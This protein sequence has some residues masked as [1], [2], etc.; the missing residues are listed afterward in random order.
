MKM[1]EFE[2]PVGFK[3]MKNVRYDNVFCILYDL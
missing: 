1:F 2:N 3:D